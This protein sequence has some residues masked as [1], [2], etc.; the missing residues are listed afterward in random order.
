MAIIKLQPNTKN[1]LE[2]V[3]N[4]KLPRHLLAK[5]VLEKFV[6]VYASMNVMVQHVLL[7]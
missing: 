5:E 6:R 4:L 2:Y 7:L 1:V 3:M